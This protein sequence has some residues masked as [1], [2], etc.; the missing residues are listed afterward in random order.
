M[1]V[2]PR[3]AIPTVA[4]ALFLILGA[5]VLDD[6]VL[7]GD[8][9]PVSRLP[10]S[11]SLAEVLEAFV[12]DGGVD[13]SSLAEGRAELDDYLEA[14]SLAAPEGA[15]RSEAM[16]F[17]IN[18]YNA[19]VLRLVLDHYPDIESV[20]DVSGFFKEIRQLVAGESLTLDEIEARALAFGDPRVHFAVVC[21]SESCPD[22]RSEPYAAETLEGQLDEQTRLFLADTEKGARLDAEALWLSS[23]FK[24]YSGDFTGVSR[25]VALLARGKLISW[26]EPYLPEDEIVGEGVGEASKIRFLDYDWALNDRRGR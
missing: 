15:S 1:S 5:V 8:P 6:A 3:T 22:L 12:V 2:P 13:Y 14:V 19:A 7:A 16:A 17:W 4:I 18:S 24:W 10:S 26:V 11:E 20:M 9:G 23:L 25:A 21:A